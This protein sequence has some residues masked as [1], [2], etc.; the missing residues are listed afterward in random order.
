MTDTKTNE[1]APTQG[2]SK[3]LDFTKIEDLRKYSG[4]TVNSLVSLF[5]V[6]RVTY[7]SWLKSASAKPR[8]TT[9]GKIRKVVRGLLSL[10]AANKWPT[11][12]VFLASQTERLEMLREAL[13]SL[14]KSAA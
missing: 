2:Q 3:T 10:V 7:Y 13:E 5:G 4:L 9:E 12:E 1:T 11:Q 14:D 6:S 8:K